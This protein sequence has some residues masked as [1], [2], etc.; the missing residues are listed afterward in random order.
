ME[1][2]RVS[3][4][5]HLMTPDVQ[6]KLEADDRRLVSGLSKKLSAAAIVTPAT[7][8]SKRRKGG[9]GGLGRGTNPL[10]S[11]FPFDPYLLC[12]SHVFVEPYYK[13]WDGSVGEHAEEQD[14]GA[15]ETRL[16]TGDDD[17]EVDDDDDSSLSDDESTGTT[18][19]DDSEVELSVD[20]V[21]DD[22]PHVRR[23]RSSTC[24]SLSSALSAQ[25]T[26]ETA[27]SQVIFEPAWARSMKRSR[28][29]S[30]ENGSW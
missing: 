22:P 14:D 7:L 10:D 18:S 6:S 17:N 19:E 21:P 8:E 29:P 28:A 12:R 2:L 27:L 3:R 1:F 5:H 26:A 20:K 11:F 23:S 4:V 9:V 25:K 30:I 24:T 15:D 13:H 16:V